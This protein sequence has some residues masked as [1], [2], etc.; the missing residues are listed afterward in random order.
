M[1]EDGQYMLKISAPFPLKEIYGVIPLSAKPISLDGPI[2]GK[3][4]TKKIQKY[5]LIIMLQ[6]TV[7]DTASYI[8][9]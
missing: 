5:K 2:K 9:G 7:P 8:R 4:N 1:R 6:I 3:I